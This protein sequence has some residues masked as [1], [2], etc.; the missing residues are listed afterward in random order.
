M[1][2]EE[3]REIETTQKRMVSEKVM[4]K[5]RGRKKIFADMK[6]DPSDMERGGERKI[7]GDGENT[8]CKMSSSDP[9]LR[10]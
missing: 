3:E 2:R 9:D 5:R 10:R 7:E 6:D 4:V 8:H 1:E